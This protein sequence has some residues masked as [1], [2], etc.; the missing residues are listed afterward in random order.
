MDEYE[1]PWS[2]PDGGREPPWPVCAET[3]PDPGQEP[4]WPVEELIRT[5]PD[6]GHEP[7]WPLGAPEV[8]PAVPE[9]SAPERELSDP[10][11]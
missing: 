10:R 5:P 2:P 1:R 9:P 8:E 6:P 3:P 7:A 4:P 11:P